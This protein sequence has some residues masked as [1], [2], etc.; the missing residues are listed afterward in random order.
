M[1]LCDRDIGF[2]SFYNVGKHTALRRKSKDRLDR[3]QDNVF[4]W[5]DVSTSRLLSL[6]AHTMQIQPSVLV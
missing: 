1:Y 2:T 5:S 4:E 6:F 3:Y